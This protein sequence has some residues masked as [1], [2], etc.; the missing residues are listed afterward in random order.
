MTKEGM[1]FTEE[2]F[3]RL[4]SGHEPWWPGLLALGVSEACRSWPGP[5]TSR[6]EAFASPGQATPGLELGAFY[7]QDLSRAGTLI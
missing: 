3:K 5:G 7:R 6:H 4:V 1:D 2:E